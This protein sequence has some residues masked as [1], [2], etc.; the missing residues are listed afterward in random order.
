MTGGAKQGLDYGRNN[1]GV[2]AVYGRKPREQGIGH[3]LWNQHNCDNEP[4]REVPWQIP[5]VI[6]PQ[7][8]ISGDDLF[9]VLDIFTLRCFRPPFL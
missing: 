1:G 6:A 8:S 9:E 2:K 3:P 7:P 5:P 4:S